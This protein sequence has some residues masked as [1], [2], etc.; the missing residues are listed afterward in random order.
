MHF[1]GHDLRCTRVST[2]FFPS[3]TAS[4]SAD[5]DPFSI[6]LFDLPCTYPISCCIHPPP[7]P[8]SMHASHGATVHLFWF[9][10]FFT[11]Y[12]F[13]YLELGFPRTN[14]NSPPSFPLLSPINVT[15]P[16]ICTNCRD[17]LK[18]RDERFFRSLFNIYIVVMTALRVG[19]I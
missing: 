3:L 16:E 11:I 1:A 8:P 7:L 15:L 10:F 2:L 6:F 14:P 18:K 19:S 17:N 5:K 9:F 13:S 12:P 4:A